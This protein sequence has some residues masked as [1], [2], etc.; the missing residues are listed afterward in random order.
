MKQHSVT[1]KW[2][3]AILALGVITYL[4]IYIF[5]GWNDDLITAPAYSAV[6]SV[7]VNVP[8]IVVRE[9]T[10]LPGSGSFV[11]LVPGEGE[12]VAAGQTVAILY[13]QA[14][15]L[16]TRQAIKTLS[17]EL[18]QLNY[19]SST[20]SDGA[21]VSKLESSVLQA[22]SNI[23]VLSASDDL[24]S[25]EDSAL[26]L[27]TAVFR[28]DYT[29][30]NNAAVSGIASL[31]AEKQAQLQQLQASLSQVS[32]VISAPCSGIFSGVADGFENIAPDSV[33]AMKPSELS[34]LIRQ[35]PASP[36]GTV[37]KLITSSTW[38]FAAVLGEEDAKKFLEGQSYAVTF[39]HD[40]FGA[41]DMTLEWISDKED[42]QV[43]ALFS[44]R[45][46][47]SETTLLRTQ[48]VDIATQQ[49][50]GIRVPRRALRVITETVTDKETGETSDLR[51]TAV[52]ALVGIQAEL[53]KVNVLYEDSNFY[54]VE[55]VDAAAVKRLRTGDIII[56]NSAD[57][58]DGKVVS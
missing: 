55:P 14:S 54:L 52:F 11:D 24:S 56:V 36:A 58:F 40:W 10:V 21:D 43:I 42:G 26:D 45:S 37:G 23:R 27:R 6:V 50:E 47:L 48:S 33:R 49:L 20:S 44:S 8:G 30:G 22:I 53:K 18:E 19:A 25:L 12:R 2:M 29:Y 17:A 31:I 13:S 9:E 5:R 41:V 16:E 34:A 46:R 32:T 39:S 3:T 4:S 28:R 57:L 15:G 7:G 1:I 51:Y 35:D 38:Y